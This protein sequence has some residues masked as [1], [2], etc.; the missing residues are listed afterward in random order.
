MA[1]VVT[2]KNSD[3][4][5]TIVFSAKAG[6]AIRR[7]EKPS[8]MRTTNF[9]QTGDTLTWSTGGNLARLSVLWLREVFTTSWSSPYT[10]L[11]RGSPTIRRHTPAW[12]ET[13]KRLYAKRGD[14]AIAS[15]GFYL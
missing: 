2:V 6:A 4:S 9:L 13:T 12:K 14:F 5:F 11:G 10:K 3:W 1:G 15:F 7:K 8:E